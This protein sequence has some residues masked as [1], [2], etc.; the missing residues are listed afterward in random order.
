MKQ[1]QLDISFGMIFSI[2]LIIAFI[3]FAVY[4][5][6][7]FLSLQKCASTGLFKN[8]LQTEIDR[9]W[10]SEETSFS[11]EIALPSQIKKI[12]FVNLSLARKG[13]FQE[14]YRQIQN[15]GGTSYNIYF[16]PLE[17]TCQGQ[18]GFLLKHIDLKKIVESKNPYC[19]SNNNGKVG[20]NI[21]GNYGRL[22]FL[23]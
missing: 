7:M 4:G 6:V 14:E 2:L 16:L 22:V 18:T 8:E 3:A 9:A 1:G 5:I 23:S 21:Q 10:N 19:I 15:Y 12:C 13:E 20:I 17:Q 11:K